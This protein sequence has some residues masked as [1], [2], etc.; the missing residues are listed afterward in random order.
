MAQF[1]IHNFKGYFI[2]LV[3]FSLGTEVIKNMMQRLA[4]KNCLNMLHKVYLLG[5]VAD[6]TQ[7]Q[8]LIESSPSPL[9]IINLY[10]DNDYILKYLLR[11]CKYDI[12][13]VGLNAIKQVEGHTVK[14][15]DC[16]Y[17]V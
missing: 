6:L 11:L 10:S 1:I 4:E 5:G 7:V 17:Y 15:E 16:T 9:T 8:M 13:P 3:G 2:N 12:T 14:N